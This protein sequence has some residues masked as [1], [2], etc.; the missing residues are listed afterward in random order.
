M[1]RTGENIYKR[2]D[3]R[4]EGRFIQKDKKGA[5]HY[6]SVYARSYRE[7]KDK[8]R[9][10]KSE[11]EKRQVNSQNRAGN[12]TELSSLWI[13]AIS[14]SLKETTVIKY[15]D[16]LRCY[17]LPAFGKC[18]LSEITNEQLSDFGNELLLKGGEQKKGLSGSTV[19]EVM[20]IM[21]SIRIYAMKHDGYVI[22]TP[23][24]INIKCGMANIR[25]LSADEEK[26][27]LNYL[28]AHI[29][30][31]NLGILLCLFTGIRIGE[32]CALKWD[33]F[34]FD[35]E[36]VK[37]TKT[38]QRIRRQD[39]AENKTEIRILK[40]KSEC[41][42]R[43]IPIPDCLRLLLME[44]RR[45]GAYILTG[46][47]EKFMEPRALQYRFKAVLKKCGLE[48]A[49]FHTTRHTFATRCVEKGFD[50]KCLTEILGHANVSITLNRYVHPAMKLKEENM[51]LLSDL[52]P[53]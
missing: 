29:N 16:L 21:N 53:V 48:D 24:C 34:D 46:E 8:L 32:V 7:V 42:V 11:F 45:E 9:N 36:R 19:R 44:Y 38:M 47:K 30:P 12:V 27:L 35:I 5:A 51:E 13:N 20:S 25:V 40:P 23:E 31:A 28:C 10:A 17:I 39:T 6:H 15:K 3:G 1:S 14:Q 49:N 18:E 4:W 41:S 26:I 22:Y 33:D 50:I 37:I 52:L 2:K 43:T